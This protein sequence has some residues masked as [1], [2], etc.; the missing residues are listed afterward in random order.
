MLLGTLP[1]LVGGSE[2]NKNIL[3]AYCRVITKPDS[4]RYEVGGH[5]VTAVVR[6]ILR[7]QFQIDVCEQFCIHYHLP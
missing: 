4:P 2:E 5:I 7:L 3:E 6:I 1:Q